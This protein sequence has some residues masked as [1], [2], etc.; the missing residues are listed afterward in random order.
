MRC[1]ASVVV[2]PRIDVLVEMCYRLRWRRRPA[3]YSATWPVLDNSRMARLLVI[4]AGFA[5]LAAAHELA[6]V[7]YRVTVLEARD[8][9]GGRVLTLTDLTPGK[10]VEGGG[11]LTGPNQPTWMALGRR[12]GLR[13]Y[14]VNWGDADFNAPIVLDGRRV[15]RAES[16]TV[17]GELDEAHRLFHADVATAGCRRRRQP[18][19]QRRQK[20]TR[21]MTRVPRAR[22]STFLKQFRQHKI[23]DDRSESVA[24]FL[25]C[26]CY[27]PD[28][29]GVIDRHHT[30]KGER[31]Q[32]LDKRLGETVEI[33]GQ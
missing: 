26:L 24:V 15:T 27:R 20:D 33:L 28:L 22:Q 9:F 30:A 10:A 18:A 8:R 7:G 4:G 1:G 16:D 25:A 21:L 5:G 2:Q 14:E 12:F 11:E 6:S 23:L 32:L 3:I 17:F 29:L 19:N 31:G 13:F